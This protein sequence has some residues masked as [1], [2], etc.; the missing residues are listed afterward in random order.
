MKRNTADEART[1]IRNPLR[2]LNPGQEGDFLLRLE[3][4][5]HFDY[6]REP[7]RNASHAHTRARVS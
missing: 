4:P 7:I 2:I 5:M 3:N 6:F 1:E